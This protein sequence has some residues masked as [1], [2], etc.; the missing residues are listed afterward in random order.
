M[1]LSKLFLVA[2]VGMLLA[3]MARAADIRTDDIRFGALCYHDVVDES[4]QGL[5]RGEQVFVGEMQRQ[6]FPQTITVQK[7]VAHF[8]WLKANGYTPVSWQQVEDARAGRSR[9]PEKPV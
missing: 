5:A 4:P 1:K 2:L 9:L 7:L 3:G 6:Y 8:N